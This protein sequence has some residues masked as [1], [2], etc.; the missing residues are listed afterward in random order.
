MCPDDSGARR[1]SRGADYRRGRRRADPDA[2]RP[3]HQRRRWLSVHALHPRPLSDIAGSLL[4]CPCVG[5]VGSRA[6]SS[7]PPSSPDCLPDARPGWQLIPN[8]PPIRPGIP[9][10]ARPPAPRPGVHK[11]SGP[12]QRSG[13]AGLHRQDRG[14]RNPGDPR[15]G[16]GMR[17]LRRRPLTWSDGI[18]RCGGPGRWGAPPDA[19]PLVFTTGTD[20]P[21]SL[22][23]PGLAG[24][25]GFRRAQGATDRRGG[26]AWMGLLSP[27]RL[28]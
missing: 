17:R 28:R 7:S 27:Y 9:T 5:T 14:R 1:R 10:T 23:L 26:P 24:A 4:W 16:H 15:S 19:G 6:R 20:L 18:H 2:P 13:V 12:S 11:R 21:S 8:S 25:I 22:Q 3:R